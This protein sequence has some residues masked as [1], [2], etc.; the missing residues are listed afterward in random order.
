MKKMFFAVLAASF[1]LASCNQ[2]KVA[3]EKTDNPSVQKNLDADH[4]ISKAFET[5]D[6]SKLDEVVAADV[7]DHSDMGD[8]KGIDSLKAMIKWMHDNLKDMKM[9]T[10]REWADDEYVATWERYY[11]SNPDGAGG[12]PKGPYDM[13]GVEVT[14]YKDGKAVEHWGFMNSQDVSK[15]MSS[16]MPP[17][18]SSMHH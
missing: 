4:A 1:F 8:K 11:G 16:M 5:G 6:V 14:K 9:E 10:K 7:L 2:T 13:Q 15:M 17:K 3:G 12:M 18:D